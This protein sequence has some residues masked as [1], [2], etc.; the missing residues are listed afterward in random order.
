[1]SVWNFVYVT[2][3]LVLRLHE[4]KIIFFRL[5]SRQT[6]T[7]RHKHVDT[8]WFRITSGTCIIP[9]VSYLRLSYDQSTVRS[10]TWRCLNCDVP[11]RVIV[12]DHTVVPLPEH[13]LRRCGTLLRKK[14]KNKKSIF[15]KIALLKGQGAIKD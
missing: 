15:F 4:L 2:F 8:R 13:I 9:A 14:K 6:L 12:V 3:F 10:R 7:F 11:S 1:M 5:T